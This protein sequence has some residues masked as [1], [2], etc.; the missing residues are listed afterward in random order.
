MGAYIPIPREKLGDEMGHLIH[1]SWAT[2]RYHG[3]CWR[4]KQIDGDRIYV[5]TPKTRKGRW[6]KASDACYTRLHQPQEEAAGLTRK[7]TN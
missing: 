3:C 4:L 7:E 6:A 5:E 2:G 1:L